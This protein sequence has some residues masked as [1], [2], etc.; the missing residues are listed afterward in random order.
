MCPWESLLRAG[1]ASTHPR[2]AVLVIIHPLR[3][4]AKVIF[5]LD[6]EAKTTGR[7]CR[8]GCCR[9]TNRAYGRTVPYL[10]YNPCVTLLLDDDRL[11]YSN[12]GSTVPD[13]ADGPIRMLP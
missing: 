3:L 7:L 4:L 5:P 1:T 10:T 13:D 8:N 2:F 12:P 11:Q 6:I 9:R